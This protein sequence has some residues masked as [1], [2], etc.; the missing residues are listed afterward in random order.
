MSNVVSL[1]EC[2]A[3]ISINLQLELQWMMVWQSIDLGLN[4]YTIPHFHMIP[5]KYFYKYNHKFVLVMW[6]T[7]S[8]GTNTFAKQRID[9]STSFGMFFYYYIIYCTF[10]SMFFMS[11]PV[12]DK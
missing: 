10:M 7:N 6:K 8:W 2:N 12:M 11:I 5:L 3:G 4:T 1:Q 9:I